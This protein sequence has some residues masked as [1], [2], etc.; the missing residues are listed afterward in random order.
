MRKISTIAAAIVFATTVPALASSD[1]A[2][3]RQKADG[4]PLSIQEIKDKVASMGYEVGDVEHDDGCVEVHATDRDGTRL[5]LK[6][7]PVTGQVV[8]SERK[9]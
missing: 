4:Q 2:S 5:E 1:D 3:C 6:M 7:H 9:S 8:E